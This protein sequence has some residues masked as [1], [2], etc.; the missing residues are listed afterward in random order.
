MRSWEFEDGLEVKVDM[1]IEIVIEF[2][3]RIEVDLEI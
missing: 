1:K 2:V 3:F